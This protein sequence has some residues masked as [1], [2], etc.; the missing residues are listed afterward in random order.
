M[1]RWTKASALEDGPSGKSSNVEVAS[2]HSF[3]DAGFTV[4][5]A[6][7]FEYGPPILEAL[8]GT[9]VVDNIYFGREP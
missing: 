3:L 9:Y 4:V 6:L 2:N 8:S 7:R 5:G 1:A